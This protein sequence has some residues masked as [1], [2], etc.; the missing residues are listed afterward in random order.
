MM[1]L[2]YI[3]SVAIVGVALFGS[4]AFGQTRDVNSMFGSRTLGGTSAGGGRTSFG[5]PGSQVE[6][7]M[8]GAGELTGSE[9]FVRGGRQP[10]QFVGSDTG[11]MSQTIFGNAAGGGNAGGPDLSGLANLANRNANRGRT[12]GGQ[13]G[14]N[15]V[16]YS[17]GLKVGFE[18][19]LP[20]APA[21][22]SRIEERLAKMSL[23]EDYGPLEVT[24]EGRTATIRGVVATRR[25]RDLVGHLVRME[26]GISTV[27]N[28]VTLPSPSD[29]PVP[30]QTP[31]A[32]NGPDAAPVTP[33]ANASSPG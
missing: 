16:S 11:D 33:P 20:T 14:Q 1:R 22:S 5:T 29:L 21:L 18:Y 13:S 6:Q 12:G 19:R 24:L 28:E 7:A 30:G 23:G 10:G 17:T 9:R 27:E 25:E 4:T 26:P 32:A 31:P 2:K 8:S 3:G 15:R